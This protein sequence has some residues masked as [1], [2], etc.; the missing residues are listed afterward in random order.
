MLEKISED[1][2]EKYERNIVEEWMGYAGRLT[3]R[4]HEKA[5]AAAGGG[6]LAAQLG[7]HPP[8]AEA[9]VFPVSR[10]TAGVRTRLRRDYADSCMAAEF[11]DWPLVGP[12]TVVWVLGFC[13]AQ[14]SGGLVARTQMSMSLCKL[15]FADGGMM[16]CNLIARCLDMAL[17]WD[18]LSIGN[19]ACME[20]LARR[21][22]LIQGKYRHSVPS[23]EPRSVIDPDADSVLFL[24]LGPGSSFG[25]QSI[26]VMP[27]LSTFITSSARSC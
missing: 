10:N 2:V 9:R 18:H 27:E 16:E 3:P 17:Q 25:R 19:L 8:D 7:G 26:C 13:L 15:S 24:G 21:F 4:S 1:Y 12:R 20:L 6:L 5:G 14:C 22:R 11:D 23:V